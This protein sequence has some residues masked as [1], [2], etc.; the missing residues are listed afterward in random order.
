MHD[1]Q[2]LTEH[3]KRDVACLEAISKAVA[4]A[5]QLFEK[6]A[7][8]SA[9]ASA[10]TVATA[11]VVI[12]KLTSAVDNY[13]LKEALVFFG[14]TF[15]GSTV[16]MACSGWQG[17]LVFDLIAGMQDPDP[18]SRKTRKRREKSL[19][20][21]FSVWIGSRIVNMLGYAHGIFFTMLALGF[22]DYIRFALDSFNKLG[23]LPAIK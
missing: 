21:V 22:Y 16:A 5:T 2:P 19:R 4:I 3:E 11:L 17:V 18:L 8:A 15:A 13:H 14:I 1:T 10:G 7:V 9:S 6:Y 12:P 23:T 20:E